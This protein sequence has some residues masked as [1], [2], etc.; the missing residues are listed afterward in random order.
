MN[1]KRL[2]CLASVL[3]GSIALSCGS[4]LTGPHNI[5]LIT[6]DT[7][8]ADR[9]SS[10]GYFR[11]TSPNL[12][13]FSKD[14]LVFERCY[15]PI[16]TTLPS[17]LSLFTGTYPEEHS[18]LANARDSKRRFVPSPTLKTFA[19]LASDAGYRTGAFVSGAPV[20]RFTGLD[21]GFDEFDEPEGPERP[22]EE[23][24]E[25]VYKWL[26]EIGD[27]PYFLWIHY[28]DPHSPFAPPPPFDAVYM[29]DEE[30]IFYL[31]EHSFIRGDVE[32]G[33]TTYKTAD[34]N[35]LYDGEVRY[36]DQQFG[37]LIDKLSGT[38]RWERTAVVIAGDHGE[39]LGQHDL[40]HHGDVW[41]EQLR[42]PLIIKVPGKP[43]FRVRNP[44]SIVDV[45]PTLLGLVEFPGAGPF[46]S[47]A[48][49]VDIMATEA[50]PYR[51]AQS[52]AR[53]MGDN[54]ISEHYSISGNR[55]KYHH[56]LSGDDA[57]FDLS[58]DP[59][60]LTN[61]IAEQPDTAA[62]LLR[63]IQETIAKQ[64]ENHQKFFAD[65]PSKSEL[66]DPKALKELR[67]LGYID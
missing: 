11:N 60:E 1:R 58:L 10:Y 24:N 14:A 2:L 28:F 51:F 34:I 65:A 9:L 48:T 29:T 23:T 3:I 37:K 66:L 61:V 64:T 12:D 40:W 46:L 57:L 62:A 59:Y 42:V 41:E 27:E 21:S 50:V 16:A 7:M 4:E 20:K 19:K 56:R 32:M 47:Q 49:G 54:L 15:A 63:T 36:V 13:S 33:G 67:A 44:I 22:A 43:G 52:R 55:W 8:R 53:E 6:I 5:V 17:H 26:E 18:V 45:F 35:N 39:A 25:A 30:Q 31:G 38:S